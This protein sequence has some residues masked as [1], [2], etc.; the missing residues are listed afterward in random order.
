M[1][2]MRSIPPAGVRG[3][4]RQRIAPRVDFISSMNT[5][6]CPE[7]GQKVAARLGRAP[8]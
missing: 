6:I 5:C 7:R 1:A 3:A 2:K 8:R 4:L